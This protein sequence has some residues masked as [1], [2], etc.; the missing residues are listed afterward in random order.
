[1]DYGIREETM[2]TIKGHPRGPVRLVF[3]QTCRLHCFIARYESEGPVILSSMPIF[4]R[5]QGLEEVHT[6]A[7]L[8]QITGAEELYLTREVLE[9]CFHNREKLE[10]MHAANK[11]HGCEFFKDLEDLPQPLSEDMTVPRDPRKLN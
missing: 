3:C 11:A 4:T 6:L 7:D 10:L 5:V 2:T 1:M 9:H 8:G